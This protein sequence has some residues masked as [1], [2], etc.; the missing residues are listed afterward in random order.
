MAAV[1]ESH[2]NRYSVVRL[3]PLDS[4]KNGKLR[5]AD[6]CLAIVAWFKEL[7]LIVIG[8]FYFGLLKSLG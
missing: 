3:N 7:M 5:S 6:Y 4:A 8:A 2:R 1:L